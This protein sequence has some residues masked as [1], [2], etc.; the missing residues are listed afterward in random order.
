MKFKIGFTIESETLFRALAQFLPVDDLHVEEVAPAPAWRPTPSAIAKPPKLTVTVK[1]K[2]RATRGVDLQAG[3]NR[4]IMEALADGQVHRAEGMKP[5]IRAGGY[6][7]N[8]AGSRLQ[9][10]RGH[11]VVE[12]MGNGGWRLAQKKQSA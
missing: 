4:I 3:I 8:S 12:Q 9:A 10:L 7:D 1:K 11:G 6:S 2:R 5:L